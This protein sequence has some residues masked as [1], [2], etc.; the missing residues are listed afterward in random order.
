MTRQFELMLMEMRER[1]HDETEITELKDIHSDLKALSVKLR[2]LNAH[3]PLRNK[4]VESEI[5]VERQLGVK[6]R[7]LVSHGGDR[8][9][10]VQRVTLSELGVSQTQYYRWR[11]LASVPEHVLESYLDRYSEGEFLVTRKG[12]LDY[13]EAIKA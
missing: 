8:R 12:L 7:G 1:I 4:A 9:S 3:L 11:R 10:S 13:W 2:L 6:I 5:H